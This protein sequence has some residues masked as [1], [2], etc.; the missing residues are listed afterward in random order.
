MCQRAKKYLTN[1]LI[2]IKLITEIK[3]E[4]N[5]YLYIRT[6][7]GSIQGQGQVFSAKPQLI[8]RPGDKAG[9]MHNLRDPYREYV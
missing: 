1:I 3:S 4:F 6:M 5:S 8:N 9:Q 2:N 7:Q